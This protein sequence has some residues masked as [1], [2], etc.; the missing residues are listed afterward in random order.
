MHADAKRLVGRTYA[1]APE[2]DGRVLL[3]KGAAEPGSIVEVT[4]TAADDYELEG[5]LATAKAKPEKA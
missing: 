5:S 2:V 3:P 1:D 4:I